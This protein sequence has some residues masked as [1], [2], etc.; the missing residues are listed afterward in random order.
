ME[1]VQHIA[2]TY[3]ISY[4]NYNFLKES[5]F[6]PEDFVNFKC[7]QQSNPKHSTPTTFNNL[8]NKTIVMQKDIVNDWLCLGKRDP[9]NYQSLK[10][11]QHWDS[12]GRNILLC[13]CTDGISNLLNPGFQPV[14]EVEEQLD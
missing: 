7:S 9:K 13:D 5:Q 14:S 10:N 11:E 4:S 3:Q 8:S 2:E 12:W 6:K 1:W